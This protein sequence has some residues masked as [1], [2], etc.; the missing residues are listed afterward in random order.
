F[1]RV[2]PERAQN[3]VHQIRII[4]GQTLGYLAAQSHQ[5]NLRINLVEQLEGDGVVELE[6]QTQCVES[7]SQIGCAGRY[8]NCDA[9]YLTGFLG[10]LAGRDF[11]APHFPAH[12]PI[13]SFNLSSSGGTAVRSAFTR[14]MAVLGSL[15]PL[16][17]RTQ[18]TQTLPEMVPSL[19]CL[20]RPA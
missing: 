19:M 2:L 11:L 10:L 12:S 9:L 15:R 7:G 4:G 20:M 16:P 13:T 14:F 1:R 5:R 6:S 3:A 17:V 18:V 8:L